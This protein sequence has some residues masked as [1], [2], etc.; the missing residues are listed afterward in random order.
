MP[1]QLEQGLYVA[2]LGMGI[3]LLSLV[4][5]LVIVLLLDKLFREND[6]LSVD[7]PI[8]QSDLHNV[9]RDPKPL[10]TAP[11]QSLTKSNRGKSNEEVAAMAVSLYL[12]LEQEF[13]IDNQNLGKPQYT[14]FSNKWKNQGRST[15]MEGQGHRPPP[16]SKS[17]SWA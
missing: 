10:N 12:S 1:D 17:H 14:S 6:E 8:R 11:S 5:L 13:D 3:V 7:K 15:L 2:A 16:F 4:V 9:D